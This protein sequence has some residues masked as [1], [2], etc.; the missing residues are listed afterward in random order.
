MVVV[1]DALERDH[2]QRPVELAVAAAVEPV[3]L[4]LA[5]GRVDWGGA[6]ERGEGGF[7]CHPPRV[8]AGDQ[9]L[10]RTH[11]AD[12]ALVEQF[13]CQIGDQACELLID[14][15]DLAVRCWIRPAIRRATSLAPSLL[16]R[17]RAAVV[18][19]C[20]LGTRPSR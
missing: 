2:V 8:A 13:G 10:R 19:S 4:L 5:A 12:A 14:I 9:Q 20:L 6:G 7:A 16:G 17:S 11:G 1:V 15:L 18:T 3:A